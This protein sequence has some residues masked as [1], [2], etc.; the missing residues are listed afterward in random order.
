LVFHVKQQCPKADVQRLGSRRFCR[1]AQ[2][3]ALGDMVAQAEEEEEEMKAMEKP[4]E[5]L[6]P[7]PMMET[8]LLG[9]QLSQVINDPELRFDLGAQIDGVQASMG[10]FTYAFSPNAE[11]RAPLTFKSSTHS[12]AVTWPSG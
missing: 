2:Q 4:S 10:S 1:Q 11:P 12:F 9:Q 7:T 3:E 5:L 6:I 8:S